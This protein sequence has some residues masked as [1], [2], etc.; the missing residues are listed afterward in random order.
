MKNLKKGEVISNK[1][2]KSI[3]PG[4]GL[5]PKYFEEILGKKVLIDVEAGT[6]ANWDHIE[7]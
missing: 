1:N 3:R 4:H 2:T 5:A 6:A 7:K